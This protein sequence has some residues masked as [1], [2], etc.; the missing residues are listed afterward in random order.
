MV[1]IP[2]GEFTMGSNEHYPEEAPAH[3]VSVDGFRMDATAVTNA[4]FRSFVEET[5]YLT[6]AERPLD[7]ADFPGAPSGEPRPGLARLHA[8]PGS[9]RSA[10][11]EPVVDVDA[12]RLLEAS[13][14]AGFVAGR[15]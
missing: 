14:R 13:G 1:G 4:E 15:S 11:H 6:V 8:D 3:R 10:A 7:P 9:G 5:G 12:G 2:G